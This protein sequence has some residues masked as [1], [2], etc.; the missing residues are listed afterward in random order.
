M[1]Q[2]RSSPSPS[3]PF[4]SMNGSAFNLNASTASAVGTKPPGISTIQKPVPNAVPPTPVCLLCV[5]VC[6]CV[7]VHHSNFYALSRSYV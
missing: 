1:G 3:L 5:C 7:C 2:N 4:S 6:V